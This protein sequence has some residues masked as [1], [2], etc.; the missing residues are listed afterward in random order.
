MLKKGF[1]LLMTLRHDK[2]PKEIPAHYLHKNPT[3][4]GNSAVKCSHYNKPIVTVKNIEDP[5]THIKYKRVR[6]SFQS[7][8]S[9]CAPAVNML[10]SV[11][12]FEESMSVLIHD[13]IYI[14]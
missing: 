8:F 3:D 12:K 1:G 6:V 9:C 14:Q 10:S 7:T 5:E 2:L 4:H 13:A 11:S